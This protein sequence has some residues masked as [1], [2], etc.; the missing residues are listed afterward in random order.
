VVYSNSNLG[1]GSVPYLKIHFIGTES[2]P[3]QLSSKRNKCGGY[4][5]GNSTQIINAAMSKKLHFKIK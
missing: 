3:V 4:G 1:Y 2:D 5:K